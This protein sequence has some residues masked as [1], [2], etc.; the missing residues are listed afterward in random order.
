MKIVRRVYHNVVSE[1]VALESAAQP[2]CAHSTRVLKLEW[3]ESD[4]PAQTLRQ[5]SADGEDVIHAGPER[6]PRITDEM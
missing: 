2:V 1:D 6:T 4:G 3:G 5:H